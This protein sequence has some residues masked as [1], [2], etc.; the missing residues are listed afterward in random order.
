MQ[1]QATAVEPWHRAAWNFAMGAGGLP[2]GRVDFGLLLHLEVHKV[3]GSSQVLDSHSAN[4]SGD[5][6]PH[7]VTHARGR[8]QGPAVFLSSP[9]GV[10][11]RCAGEN[12][13]F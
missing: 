8:R 6:V 13:M 5:S 4:N 11:G 12:E 9:M 3:I 10:A 2:G 7:E 1:Q